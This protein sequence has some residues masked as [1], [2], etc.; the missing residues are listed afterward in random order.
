MLADTKYAGQACKMLLIILNL[1]TFVLVISFVPDFLVFRIMQMFY[2][3]K[4]V[5]LFIPQRKHKRRT[6]NQQCM[7][8]QQPIRQTF[9]TE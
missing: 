5:S 7:T 6:R 1:Q 9:R 8:V 3:L 4:K 2:L